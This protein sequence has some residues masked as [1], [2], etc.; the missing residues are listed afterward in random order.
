LT[1]STEFDSQV[2]SPVNELA[3]FARFPD[4]GYQQPL[5]SGRNV[6]FALGIADTLPPQEHLDL[7]FGGLDFLPARYE[8]AAHMN[9]PNTVV[10]FSFHP[11]DVEPCAG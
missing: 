3:G 4:E 9:D 1:F 11:W 2:S 6:D 8:A 7:V 5:A 10:V